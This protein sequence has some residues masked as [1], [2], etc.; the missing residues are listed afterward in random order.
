MQHTHL[1]SE[2]VEMFVE[3]LGAKTLS[4]DEMRKKFSTCNNSLSE[5]DS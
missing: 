2:T 3:E 1:V 5:K 4:G